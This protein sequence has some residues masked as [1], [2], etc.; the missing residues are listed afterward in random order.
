MQQRLTRFVLIGLM[1]I[2]ALLTQAQ[3][4]FPVNGPHDI[5]PHKYAI[6][7]ANIYVDAEHLLQD[8]QL[9]IKDGI[10]E[11]VGKQHT[12][13]TD[14]ALIDIHNRYIYPSFIDLYSH[15]GLTDVPR[16]PNT[17]QGLRSS[18]PGAYH[19]N[20]SLQPE[21]NAGFGFEPN[22]KESEKLMASGFGAVV[23][24]YHEGICSGAS[25]L[26][27]TAPGKAHEML[28]QAPVSNTFSFNPK[29]SGTEYPNSLMGMIALIRQA[30]L[31][32]AWYPK[33]QAEKNISLEAF[34]ALQKWPSLFETENV[35]SALRA[36]KIAQEFGL[37]YYIKGNGD[38]YQRASELKN[39]GARM[40]IP[41][42][43]PKPFDITTIYQ[44]HAYPY[45][46]L[47]HWEM[48][49]ANAAILAE[50]NIPFVLSGY[51][52]DAESFWKN[53]R[54]AIKHGLP[55]KEAL[56]AL[57]IYP[58]TW[59]HQDKTVGSLHVGKMANFLVFDKPMF[60][61]DAQ[62]CEHWIHGKK[63]NIQTI[64]Y[65]D[66]R[67]IYTFQKGFT[68]QAKL[69]IQG[70]AS[71]RK[72][73]I[74]QGKDSLKASYTMLGEDIQ[75]RF[76]STY[77]KQKIS[78]WM[79]LRSSQQ[80]DTLSGYFRGKSLSLQAVSAVRIN[81]SESKD[82]T[83]KKDSI[84]F[85]SHTALVYPFCEYGRAKMPEAED[86]LF[87]H[88]TIW[89]NESEG[90][91]N[92]ADIH[93]RDGK[94]IAVGKNLPA[95]GAQ[96]IDAQGKHISA[97]IID[98]HSHIALY[99]GVNECSQAITAE[100]RI[101]DVINSEDINIYRQLSGGV[102]A[103]QLLHGSCNP[104][105][106][107]SG[108]IKLRWGAAPEAM[109]IQ[110]ADGF[111]K[112]ALGENVKRSNSGDTW[113]YPQ[114]RMGVEQLIYDGFKRA[115]DY[116]IQLKSHPET[117]R[118][119]L[120]LE[121][122]VEILHRK[123]FISCHS[124]V[125]S[126]INMLMHVADSFG[127]KVN[128][129]THILEGYKVADKMKA[130]GVHAST[131]ADW[132]GYKFEVNEA[133]PYNAAIMHKAGIYVAINSDDAEMGR[134]LN[135][136]AA[137]TI[138]YGGVS[139][140]DA[141]KMVTLNPAIMLHLDSHMGS[142]KAGK[143]ADFVVWTNHPLSIQAEAEMTFVDG[144]KM[145]DKHETEQLKATFDAERARLIQKMIEAKM[146]GEKTRTYAPEPEFDYHC[147]D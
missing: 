75:I 41:L 138:R 106:G 17:H 95:S 51:G 145:Y 143:D 78:C 25:A 46:E 92:D 70:H 68:S 141:L 91:L 94:I 114:T 131:F 20:E 137:K 49:P 35:L 146:R 97:G 55:E 130:H 134:R 73:W 19:W 16:Y 59:I 6:I 18:K 74:V 136:E 87:T 77:Q 32:A 10:I 76:D 99:R 89:T 147:E 111:I 3:E 15:Y 121:T 38:E 72:A 98:E 14:Y 93:I 96:V 102:V 105:G 43:F 42:N 112:F 133:I 2:R 113:R 125:Q 50:Q 33:Q 4:S 80:G 140:E 23:T 104:I 48:A 57:T 109:K 90:V 21:L 28:L 36:Q 44:A 79:Q 65:N 34:I 108:L 12:I 7:H 71:A 128:T 30:Y 24:S 66:V 84:A 29:P 9:L 103:S 83:S 82:S 11:A 61:D 115:Q 22:E 101:G 39:A 123:R 132:W 58:A 1:G 117:T 139:E 110:G 13:P 67:G 40:I 37:T 45:R 81:L 88:A 27:L 69:I 142:L 126:E 52:C 8:A 54:L 31:D 86:V 100:V 129:F 118:R 56:R 47:K 135:Q 127:F 122:L 107:Q 116:E 119:D 5:R 120:E 144:K 64:P 53:I 26:V 62:L 63:H 85:P 60:T 124:Y